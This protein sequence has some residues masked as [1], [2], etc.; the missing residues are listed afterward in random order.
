MAEMK[1]VFK[2]PY[3]FEGEEHKEI[4]LEGLE[5]LS[6]KDLVEADRR[7]NASGSMALMNEMQTGYALIIAA[8]ATRKPIEFFENLPASEGLKVKNRVMGFLNA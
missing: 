1:I 3:Q 5:N 2:K 4:N 8:K 6:A 7:F